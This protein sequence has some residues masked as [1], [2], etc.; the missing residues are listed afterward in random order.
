MKLSVSR[1]STH[2]RCG[3]RERW[4]FVDRLEHNDDVA[5]A[6]P[7][8]ERQVGLAVH[9]ALERTWKW[10]AA[11]KFAGR[12]D[13]ANML[14]RVR[15]TVDDIADR[16][17][18][19]DDLRDDAIGQCV[20]YLIDVEHVRGGALLG[21]E[22]S[23]R[24][25]IHC[26]D[27]THQWNGVLD[28]AERTEQRGVV[29]IVDLKTGEFLPDADHLRTDL[30]ANCYTIAASRKWKWASRI[31]FRIDN[32]RLR[33]HRLIVRDV[34]EIEWLDGHVRGE[35][36]EAVAEMGDSEIVARAG[37]HCHH[38]PFRPVCPAHGG[39]PP[40]DAT[41]PTRV[42]DEDAPVNAQGGPP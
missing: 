13:T 19:A 36:C 33:D 29:R 28:R 41:Q 34:A 14:G 26:D 32:T 39:T 35:L 7:P 5:A 15:A 23:L 9:E 11:S 27:D 31:E 3:L 30:Q 25:P 24:M 21:I 42:V 20:D 1:I 22:E 2:R 40:D 17:G 4:Q 18:L 37:S 16:D 6:P 8:P 38:C 10:F 12:T